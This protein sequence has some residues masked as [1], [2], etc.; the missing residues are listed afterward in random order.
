MKNKVLTLFFIILSTTV[1]AQHEHH[2]ATSDTKVVSQTSVTFKDEKLGVAYAQYILLK[3]AL[4]ASNADEAQKSVSELVKTLA[5]LKN[6]KDAL[7]AATKL[8]G[9]SSLT[10][11]R[12]N[13]STLSDEM[14]KLVEGGKL[15]SG[16]LYLEYCPMANKNE[17]AYWLS[18][19]KEIKNP[20]FGSMMLKCG[21]VKETIQ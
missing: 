19:E 13:F 1:F 21:S 4:V 5:A 10:E 8:E 7:Q 17:G 16:S 2:A 20:Y 14:V 9:T 18:N 12:L 11:Q 3:D 6:G 15:S